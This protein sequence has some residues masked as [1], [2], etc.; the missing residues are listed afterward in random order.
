MST[1]GVIPHRLIPGAIVDVAPGAFGVRAVNLAATGFGT[2]EW[3]QYE[4]PSFAE[5][6]P[7]GITLEGG[8]AFVGK[9]KS[10]SGDENFCCLNAETTL[11]MPGNGRK[12]QI[13]ALSTKQVLLVQKAA[14]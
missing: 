11:V 13:Q 6:D 4:S 3:D 7:V 5:G 2:A 1:Y 9:V 8:T 14:E 10:I 12:N